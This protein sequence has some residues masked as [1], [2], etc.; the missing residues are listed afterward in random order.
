MAVDGDLRTHDPGIVV[1]DGGRPWFVF[2]TGDPKVGDGA[3]QVRTSPD[4]EYWTHV[5]QAWTPEDGPGW[6]REQVPGVTNFW[7][8]EVVE[9]EGTWYLY[10]AASTFG[11]NT[12]AI[13]LRTA[14]TLDPQDP[15]AGWTDRGEVIS[16]SPG[17]NWNAIDPAVLFDADGRAWLAFGS[18]WGGIQMVELEFPAGKP[19]EGAEVFNI[20]HMGTSLNAIEAPALLH[21]D[22]WY[23][24]FFS[25]DS[26]C[27]GVNSSYNINVGRSEQP[28]G[29]YVDAAGIPLTEGGGTLLLETDGD[30]IGPGGQSVSGNHI[31]YHYYDRRAGGDFRLAIREL[32]WQEG[33]PVVALED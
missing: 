6:A 28:Q 12:S 8:P 17:V 18:F 5:G 23:Y 3:I 1:G 16:S 25:A 15:A 2:S 32:G 22:D 9:H 27:Q 4:G 24:L 10:Y 21:R 14:E 30:R 13:G 29:P 11:K 33:W 20:A 26:C 7:A 19:A 31:A